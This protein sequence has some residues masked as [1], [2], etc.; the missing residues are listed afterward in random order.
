MAWNDLASARFAALNRELMREW[1]AA[2]DRRL[3]PMGLSQPKWLTLHYVSI[4]AAPPTQSELAARMAIEGPTLVRQLDRLEAGGLVTRGADPTDRRRKI[5]RLTEQA[6]GL[7]KPVEKIIQALRREF[8]AGVNDDEL[9]ICT[10]VLAQIRSN[11]DGSRA[12]PAM[13]TGAIAQKNN[14][15]K[16][17]KVA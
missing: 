1:R 3:R 8:L 13:E 7:L 9:A 4:S 5:I 14:E 17:V 15:R 11:Q 2:L 12:P 16:T 6:E 10:K